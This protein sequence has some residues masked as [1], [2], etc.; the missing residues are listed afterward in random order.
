MSFV[1][2]VS[3]TKTAQVMSKI[4]TTGAGVSIQGAL[5]AT[6]IGANLNETL[7]NAV[8]PIGSVIERPTAITNTHPDGK[9]KAFL[10][11]PSQKWELISS[12]S[13]TPNISFGVEYNAGGGYGIPLNNNTVNYSNQLIPLDLIHTNEGSAWNSTNNTFVAPKDGNYV[14]GV[15]YQQNDAG[16]RILLKRTLASSGTTIDIGDVVEYSENPSYV[17]AGFFNHGQTLLT[18][19]NENDEVFLY[20]DGNYGGGVNLL[21]SGVAT[22]PSAGTIS[23]LNFYGFLVASS[24]ST[25]TYAYK[26]ISS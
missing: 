17:Y 1:N 2:S 5:D 20:A 12:P 25:N 4:D 8:Y 9:Y 19:L 22:H 24:A 7:L 16:A 13:D 6:S 3:A 15:S 18:A 26:R 11:A 23:H 14:F 10:E 21:P